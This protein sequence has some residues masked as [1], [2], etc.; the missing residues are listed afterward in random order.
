MGV[1]WDINIHAPTEEP[2]KADSVLERM[3]QHLKQI[4]AA[5][6]KLAG[7][8]RNVGEHAKHTHE[9]FE[10]VG[11]TIEETTRKFHEFAEFTGAMLVADAIEH[12]TEKLIELGKEMVH[13]AAEGQRLTRIFESAAG[14][15]ELGRQ[16]QEWTEL[17]AKRT[18]LTDMETASS[19]LGLKRTGATD[20][21]AK[22]QSKAAA[23]IAAVSVNKSE[24][25]AATISAFERINRTG[26]V[27]NRA[28]A[29]LGIGVKDFK[30]LD[31]MKGL[32]DKEIKK[33]MEEGKVDKNDLFRLIMSRTGEKAIGEKAADNA[34]LLTTKLSKLTE[35]PERFFK[36]LGD[37]KAVGVLS[38]AIQ[39][40]LDKLDPDGPTGK[41]ILN[42]LEG[43]FSTIAEAVNN[44]DFEEVAD[45]ITEDV[46][47]AMKAMAR[48]I[49]PTIEAIERVI[50]GLHRMKEAVF[51]PSF[52]EGPAA[53]KAR[54][55]R[56]ERNAVE[57]A[58]PAKQAD[59][60][61]AKA[62]HGAF[63]LVGE[64]AGEGLA[65]GIN[66]A[67]PGVEDAGAEVAGRAARGARKKLKVKSPSVVFE[68][69]GEMTAAGFVQGI[70]RATPDVDQALQ[71]AF[72]MK[73]PQ[74]QGGARGGMMG[75][76]VLTFGD[77][78][79]YVQDSGRPEE[80]ARR[81]TDAF[82]KEIRGEFF[83]LLEQMQ[84][85]EGA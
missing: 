2:K 52:E 35:L 9:R 12:I 41:R 45:V 64:A 28:L 83:S 31:S 53:A 84:T 11:K 23:D 14:S 17:L 42:G 30:G 20:Q 25:F 38:N 69:I 59:V 49:Q 66:A 22:L 44:I 29:P 54:A 8:F 18:E 51:G 82:K 39:G 63:H 57:A 73:G 56:R 55:E 4:D 33:R 85:E 72:A 16:N 19:F 3:E 34:D 70:E 81:M 32:S 21:E 43:L 24:A 61:G 58:F 78:N 68:D 71:S 62:Y 65:E 6:G 40:M 77:L 76:V 67:A 60:S 10:G 15:K 13:N 36:K 27:S 7:G 46:L 74:L 50:R 75:S 37:T 47:P 1:D 48:M 26:V 79:F 80:N 5:T